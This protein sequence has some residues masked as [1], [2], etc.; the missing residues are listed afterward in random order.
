MR[1]QTCAATSGAIRNDHIG[2][3]HDWPLPWRLHWLH[4]DG[5]DEDGEMSEQILRDALEQI[6]SVPA[7]NTAAHRMRSIAIEALAQQPVSGVI[8]WATAAGVQSVIAKREG[9]ADNAILPL[10]TSPGG[11][12]V[13]PVFVA[14]QPAAGVELTGEE[15]SAAYD[16]GVSD[17]IARGTES[18]SHYFGLKFVIAAHEAKKNGGGQDVHD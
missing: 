9:R 10:A 16:A 5:A 12:H 14:Q 8:A 17:A 1:W 18:L 7:T 2:S 15:M 6:V 3:F 13:V 11:D 4:G